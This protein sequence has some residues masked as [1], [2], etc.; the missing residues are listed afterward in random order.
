M[1]NKKE[2]QKYFN[3]K[4]YNKDN[5]YKIIVSKIMEEENQN[6]KINIFLEISRIA[7][8]LLI[9]ILGTS[10][11]VLASVKIYNEYIK[12]KGEIQSEN[13]YL[14]EEGFYSMDFAND[15]IYEETAN[16]YYKIITNIKDY[17]KYKNI[18][19]ELPEM[20]KDEFNNNFLI[21]IASGLS[22]RPHEAD[23]IISEVD[24]DETHTY[25]TL[26]QK[27]NS[28]YDKDIF[29]LYAIINREILREKIKLNVEAPEIRSEKYVDIES[30]PNA[31]SIEDALKDGCFVIDENFKILSENKNALDDLIENSK[32]GVESFMRIYSKEKNRR[33]IIDLQYKKGIILT[34][35][36]NLDNQKIY[37]YSYK[38]LTKQLYPEGKDNIYIYGFN[39]VD[40]AIGST[41]FLAV[42][43]E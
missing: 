5:N 41:L 28:D 29:T 27:C 31:Y 18:I 11:L 37:I 20:T 2:L 14:T 30:L 16:L 42:S 36:R 9:S 24:A 26:T 22:R 33:R 32:K 39:N 43:Y 38:Y 17:N 10:S 13:L 1:K 40:S 19:E 35:V 6:I 4:Y 23:L 21:I 3:K 12:N 15:M 8:I 7:A 25:V 34:K